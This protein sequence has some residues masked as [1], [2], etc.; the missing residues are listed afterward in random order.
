[1]F[2]TETDRF[3]RTGRPLAGQRGGQTFRRPPGF[4]QTCFWSHSQANGDALIVLF[5]VGIKL[6]GR[7]PRMP[8][9][10]GLLSWISETGKS[11]GASMP[12]FQDQ[13]ELGRHHIAQE[14]EELELR[15]LVQPEPCGGQLAR[16][17]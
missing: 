6:G 3:L 14:A 5:S 13:P 8:E 2:G 1:M 15:E 11:A 7:F 9:K 4:R 10:H 12:R 17:P 16:Q